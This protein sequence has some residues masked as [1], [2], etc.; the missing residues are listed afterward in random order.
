MLPRASAAPW[1]TFRAR[2]VGAESAKIAAGALGQAVCQSSWCHQDGAVVFMSLKV[3]CRTITTTRAG[4]RCKEGGCRSPNYDPKGTI[5]PTLL[6]A[7][8]IPQSGHASSATRFPPASTARVPFTA[9]RPEGHNSHLVAFFS[10]C[11][12]PS[13]HSLVRH[14]SLNLSRTP[15]RKRTPTDW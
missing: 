3:T 7:G 11:A 2:A 14:P 8:T 1:V 5:P 12:Y 9:L 10:D 4:H 6:R 13:T 15:G